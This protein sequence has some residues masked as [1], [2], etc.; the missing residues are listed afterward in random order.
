MNAH[1]DE[2][3]L[4][5]QLH[6]VE[7]NDWRH[8]RITRNI[9]LQLGGGGSLDLDESRDTVEVKLAAA[10]EGRR[11]T[12]GSSL[13]AGIDFGLAQILLQETHCQR[14]VRTDVIV[15][16][17]TRARLIGIEDRKFD[18]KSTCLN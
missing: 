15:D 18:N 6:F 7:L 14:H 1:R 5:G 16:I 17:E 11:L 12:G 8:I 13:Q 9:R 10:V 3:C 4:D 2:I